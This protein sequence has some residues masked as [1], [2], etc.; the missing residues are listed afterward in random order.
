MSERPILKIQND[1]FDEVWFSKLSKLVFWLWK[2]L[3]NSYHSNFESSKPWFWWILTLKHVEI[4]YFFHFLE[5]KI[6]ILWKI[7]FP[8]CQNS[9]FAHIWE[10]SILI[11]VNIGSLFVKM[12]FLKRTVWIWITVISLNDDD[13]TKY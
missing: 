3:E 10:T 6:L 1:D 2:L 7:A 12:L 9:E 13:D 11:L 5:A 4:Y 8:I